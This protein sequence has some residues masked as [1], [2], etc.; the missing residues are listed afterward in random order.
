MNKK[1]IIS[2][3]EEFVKEKM[4]NYDPGHDWSH[5]ERV[6]NLAGIINSDLRAD[7]FILDLAAILHDSADSKFPGGTRYDEIVNFLES[8]GQS[9][10]TARLINVIRNIS[11]SNKNPEGD[12]NDPVYLVL[13]DADRLDAIGA[14]GVARAFSYGSYR[15]NKLYEPGDEHGGKPGTT[16]HHFY[17]KL[18]KLTELMNT[19][20]GRRLAEERHRFLEKF[21]QQFYKEWNS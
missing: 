21:L 3:A 4:K 9:A 1:E 8:S 11:F 18:L 15:K 13:Q 10:I 12:L 7:P 14:I 2:K 5:V 20:E 6:R 16:I 19:E 17:D